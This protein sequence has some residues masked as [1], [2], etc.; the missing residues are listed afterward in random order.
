MSATAELDILDAAMDLLR[1]NTPEVGG[2]AL[3]IAWPGKSFNPASSATSMWLQPSH[4]PS[5]NDNIVLAAG[6]V[7]FRGFVQILVGFRNNPLGLRPAHEVA[8][9]LVTLYA[10]GTP[11]GPVLVASRPSV[12]PAV[13]EQGAARLSQGTNYLPVSIPYLGLA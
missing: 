4:F 13:P 1:D 6:P 9:E 2:S 11:L 8:A 7:M 12:G 10:K 3:P 5:D